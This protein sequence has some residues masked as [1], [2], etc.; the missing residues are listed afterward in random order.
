MENRVFLE[1]FMWSITFIFLI[2]G[3]NINRNEIQEKI[4]VGIYEKNPIRTKNNIV[5]FR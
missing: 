5:P 1:P 3:A 4:S 2:C